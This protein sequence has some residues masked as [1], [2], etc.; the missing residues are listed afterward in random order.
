MFIKFRVQL[1]T[2]LYFNKNHAHISLKPSKS[3]LY[4]SSLRYLLRLEY[5]FAIIFRFFSKLYHAGPN[6]DR[7]LPEHSKCAAGQ[8][9]ND[10][11]P[12]SAHAVQR[13]FP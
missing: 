8:C 11:N 4:T 2:G 6:H 7:A 1:K 9:L 3:H 13:Q 12:N 5:K 10:S